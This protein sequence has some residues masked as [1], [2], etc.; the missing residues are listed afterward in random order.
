MHTTFP[1]LLSDAMVAIPLLKSTIV[2]SFPAQTAGGLYDTTDYAMLS[3]LDPN[4][5]CAETANPAERRMR[6]RQQSLGS[7][8]LLDARD[9]RFNNS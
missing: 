6:L 1:A 7:A 2:N 4:Y 9:P 3:C 8:T 5:E